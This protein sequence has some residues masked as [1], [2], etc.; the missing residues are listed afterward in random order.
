MRPVHLP[1]EDEVAQE[2]GAEHDVVDAVALEVAVAEDLPGL[3]AGEGVLD[4][5]ADLYVRAVVLLLPVAEF[6]ANGKE[7]LTDFLEDLP[8][9]AVTIALPAIPYCDVVRSDNSV[10]RPIRKRAS[11]QE[12][13]N[14]FP[15]AAS[16]PERRKPAVAKT[17]VITCNGL[18]QNL[19]SLRI[20]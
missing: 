10:A 7:W 12:K 20:P 4:A 1:S 18:R 3:R 15:L 8:S 5:S 19:L 14:P 9:A 11:R 16:R 13:G 2:G 17:S 6:C